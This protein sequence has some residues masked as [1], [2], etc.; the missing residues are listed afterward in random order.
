MNRQ[1]GPD[2]AIN[3][4]IDLC[5]LR[6]CEGT[7]TG[8]V[9]T[10]ALRLNQRA[11]LLNLG[12]EQVAQSFVEQVCCAVVTHRIFTPLGIDRALYD[13]AFTHIAFADMAIMNDKSLYRT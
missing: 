2:P 3:L 6:T 10:Q 13:I 1:I 11:A 5:Y 7:R 9:E 4:L 8:E 12:A